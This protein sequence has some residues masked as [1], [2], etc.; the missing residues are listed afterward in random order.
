[1]S[2]INSLRSGV[3]WI[4]QR[5][6]TAR[7]LIKSA[8]AKRLSLMSRR[9]NAEFAALHPGEPLPPLDLM[10]DAHAHCDYGRYYESGLFQARYT[11]DMFG[12][13]FDFSR[14][15]PVRIFEWGCGTGRLIR[16]LRKLYD[17]AAVDILASDCNPAAVE[18]CTSVFP[19]ISFFRNE[20]APPLQLDD[21]SVDIAYCSS[22]F[23]HLSDDLCRR[24]MA[25]LVRV[26]RPGGLISFTI[27]G[28]SF[29]YRYHESEKEAY[30]RGMPIYREWD[31]AG[32]RDFFAWHPPQYV[33]GVFL[34]GLDELEYASSEDS[35]LNQ[36]IW[37]ARVPGA[38]G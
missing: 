37:L 20:I 24:W 14:G 15:A 16:Q 11:A 38:V 23:T 35:G 28:M 34:S 29:A 18:W 2:V 25:E 6:R 1:V 9:R 33:R 4:S 8:K 32:R 36:D 22:V 3:G 31:E 13:H 5:N 30:R 19:D 21:D 26:V 7:Q 12:R 10:A 27:A 17:P